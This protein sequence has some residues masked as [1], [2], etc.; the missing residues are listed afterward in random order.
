MIKE[1]L[2]KKHCSGLCVKYLK[3]KWKIIVDIICPIYIEI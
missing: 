3:T 1:N 2:Q